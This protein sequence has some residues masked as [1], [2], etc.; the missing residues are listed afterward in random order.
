MIIN[1]RNN[2]VTLGKYICF[3]GCLSFFALSGCTTL[4]SGGP[5]TK[6]GTGIRYSL[7]APHIFLNPQ[8]DGTITVEVKYLPDPNNT[9]T[10]NI[11]SYLSNTTFNVG[12]ENGMLTSLALDS[13]SSEVAGK[14]ISAA[15]EIQKARMTAKQQQ[16]KTDQGKKDAIKKTTN[17]VATEIRNKVKEIALLKDKME[18]Y[19]SQPT[20]T[21]SKKE[22]L[23]LNLEISQREV[24]L[25]FLKKKLGLAK[26]GTFNDPSAFMDPIKKDDSLKKAYGPVLFRV[27]PTQ[28]SGVKL[29]AV[30]FQKTFETSTSAVPIDIP[31]SPVDLTFR[32]SKVIVKKTDTSHDI[33]IMFS[34][35]IEAIDIQRT[36]LMRPAD[37]FSSPPV[38]KGEQVPLSIESSDSKK[39]KLVLP[40]T[41]QSG[42]YRLDIAL[43]VK[44]EDGFQQQSIPIHWLVE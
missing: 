27:L 9:Y 25:D 11:D 38:L 16:L 36:Q 13:K 20:G 44:G 22:F 42:V 5:A 40:N 8:A 17:E 32:L 14:V 15:T 10:L 7:P 31:A 33:N 34:K 21:Y 26:S 1:S 12:L 30:E 18:F 24:E 3:L 6:D 37:G 19:N 2:Y 28:N 29:V 4:M 35:P 43:K 39:M 41:V 23:D